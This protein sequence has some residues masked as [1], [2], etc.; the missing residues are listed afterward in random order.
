MKRAPGAARTCV[1]PGMCFYRSLVKLLHLVTPPSAPNRACA[2]M[3]LCHFTGNARALA[4]HGKASSSENANTG[5]AQG[6]SF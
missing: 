3:Q 2:R 4:L 6:T 5:A 1:A